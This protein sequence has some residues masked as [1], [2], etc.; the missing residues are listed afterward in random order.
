MVYFCTS[1]LTSYNCMLYVSMYLLFTMHNG[2]ELKSSMRVHGLK[3]KRDTLKSIAYVAN[4]PSERLTNT[5]NFTR[6]TEK[7]EPPS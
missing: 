7:E 3:N 1:C 5:P 6:E 2:I 4:S